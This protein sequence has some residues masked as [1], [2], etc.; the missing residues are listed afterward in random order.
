MKL[1]YVTY[2]KA[3][4]RLLNTEDGKLV[5]AYW[6]L[7]KVKRTAFG[8]T[9]EQTYAKLGV[10]EFVQGLANDVN[11]PQDIEEIINRGNENDRN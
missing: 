10:K 1:N 9:P 11:N 6:T 4:K 8:K 3:V 7:D 5:L 2:R